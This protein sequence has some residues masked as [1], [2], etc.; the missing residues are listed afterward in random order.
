[1]RIYPVF[2]ILLLEPAASNSLDSMEQPEPLSII[3][4]KHQEWEV[5]EIL[6]ART[7]YRKLQFPVKW[8]NSLHSTWEIPESVKNAPFKV[9]SAKMQN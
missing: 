6:D 2:H 7:Y 4:N 3:V 9:T 8:T 5:E 1:M